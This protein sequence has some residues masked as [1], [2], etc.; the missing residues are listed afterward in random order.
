MWYA[1]LIV[2]DGVVL[3][4]TVFPALMNDVLFFT[5]GIAAGEREPPY[6]AGG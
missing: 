5:P 1:G 4:E 2:S 3:P 6:P